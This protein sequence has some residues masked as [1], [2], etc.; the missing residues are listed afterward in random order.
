MQVQRL[1]YEVNRQLLSESG[2]Q[3][4]GYHVLSALSAAPAA[5]SRSPRWPPA[6]AGAAA[7]CP[8]ARR[9]LAGWVAP[10]GLMRAAGVA[11]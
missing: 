4:G 5:D 11:A 7:A 2:P 10:G 8:A 1:S 9:G 6:S 3:L